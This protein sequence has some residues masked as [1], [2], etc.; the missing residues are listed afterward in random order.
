[1]PFF[2]RLFPFRILCVPG[3]EKV[4]I[5]TTLCAMINEFWV[6][7]VFGFGFGFRFGFIFGRS[8]KKIP[9]TLCE[10]KDRAIYMPSTFTVSDSS[11]FIEYVRWWKH[12]KEQTYSI[13][14]H[15]HILSFFQWSRTLLDSIILTY[16]PNFP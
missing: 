10:M 14:I 9:Y 8:K 3:A 11:R 5:C 7:F 4:N 1:M 13:P 16:L 12:F 15:K 6:W 2:Y